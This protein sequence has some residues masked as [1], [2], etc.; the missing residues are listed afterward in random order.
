MNVRP[1][2]DISSLDP[3]MQQAVTQVPAAAQRVMGN[4][5]PDLGRIVKN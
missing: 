2:F 4:Y 1:N 3:E 5:I